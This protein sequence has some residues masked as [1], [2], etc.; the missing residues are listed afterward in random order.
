[1]YIDSVR[2][3]TLLN[4][5]LVK[6]LPHVKLEKNYYRPSLRYNQPPVG[7]KMEKI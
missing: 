4:K 7:V 3:W 1:M 6:E 5:E 2:I